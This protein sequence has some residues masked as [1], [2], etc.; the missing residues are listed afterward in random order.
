MLD[1]IAKVDRVHNP[2]PLKTNR[3][4]DNSKRNNKDDQSPVPSEKIE[5]EEAG[6]DDGP[7]RL[8]DIRI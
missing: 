8:L 4:R 7:Q 3:D 6:N 5:T 2:E 1:D